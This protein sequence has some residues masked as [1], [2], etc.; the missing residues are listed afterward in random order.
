L[1]FLLIIIEKFKYMAYISEQICYVFS[2]DVKKMIL[3]NDRHTPNISAG[4][5]K[6]YLENKGYKLDFNFR[7]AKLG[8]LFHG[9]YNPVSNENYHVAIACCCDMDR[10]WV[11]IAQDII[12]RGT[13]YIIEC[14]P[15]ENIINL[16]SL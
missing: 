7:N 6:K 10:K 15:R 14:E 9:I 1:F 2:K 13:K 4:V 11:C 12:P 16:W 3:T 5:V 8:N